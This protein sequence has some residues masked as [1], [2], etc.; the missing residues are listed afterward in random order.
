M[1]F[2]ILFF[3]FSLASCTDYY[4]QF[5]EVGSPT[6]GEAIKEQ[7]DIDKTDTARASHSQHTKT[8]RGESS[9]GTT[10][11]DI[12]LMDRSMYYWAPA[13][14]TPIEQHI[15]FDA[16]QPPIFSPPKASHVSILHCF[17]CTH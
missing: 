13:V 9:A 17:I 7:A 6:A 16:M 2:N 5:K 10:L 12:S 4:L 15:D 11:G 1:C 14:Q 8:V 3:I